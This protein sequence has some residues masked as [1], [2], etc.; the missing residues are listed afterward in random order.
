MKK[1][2]KIENEETKICSVGL[3]TDTEFY[4]SLGMSEMDVE[5]AYNGDWYIT[6]YAPEKPQDLIIREEITE[7]KEKLSASDYAVIK[8]AEG[9]A[10]GEEYA[11]LIQQRGEWRAKINELEAELA[12]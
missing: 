3:G 1:Y 9:A 10:T 7:L 4:Q 8:I 6:G 11:E 2:A 5:Q 12:E